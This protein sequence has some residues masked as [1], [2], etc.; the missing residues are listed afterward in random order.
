VLLMMVMMIHELRLQSR[1][2]S[3]SETTKE[4]LLVILHWK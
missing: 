2:I 3:M 4:S 1:L